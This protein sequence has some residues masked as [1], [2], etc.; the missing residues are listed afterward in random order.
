MEECTLAVR[1]LDPRKRK[2]H[3]SRDRV[4]LRKD[5]LQLGHGLA[6]G[7]GRHKVSK[8]RVEAD[9]L[10]VIGNDWGEDALVAI[11]QSDIPGKRMFQY[12]SGYTVRNGLCNTYR[13]NRQGALG[14]CS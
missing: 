5:D 12:K 14:C 6:V 3:E 13:K 10:R 7:Q 1:G 11:N 8:Q 2:L 9:K 4:L